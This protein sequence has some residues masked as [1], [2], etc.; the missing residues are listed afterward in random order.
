MG[1]FKEQQQI[2]E[3]SPD[4]HQVTFQ[5]PSE[6]DDSEIDI[7]NNNGLRDGGSTGY[8]LT[9]RAQCDGGY[10]DFD[11]NFYVTPIHGLS[12]NNND[13]SL[14]INLTGSTLYVSLTDS[15]VPLGGGLYQQ[16][17]WHL[18]I[19]NASTGVS[20]YSQNV[21][22]ID[23]YVNVGGFPNGLYIVRATLNGILYTAKFFN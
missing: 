9:L 2:R 20:Y 10:Y 21:T 22:G 1:L 12:S 14:L 11:L 17:P 16:L 4:L 5:L 23:T 8:L 19:V 7:L 3:P 6:S 13:P 15:Q 18:N